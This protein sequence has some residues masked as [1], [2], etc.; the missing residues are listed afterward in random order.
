MRQSPFVQTRIPHLI[1]VGTADFRPARPVCDR[2]NLYSFR[3][4]QPWLTDSRNQPPPGLVNGR[5][6]KSLSF[7]WWDFATEEVRRQYQSCQIDSRRMSY[8]LDMKFDLLEDLVAGKLVALGFREGA[9]VAEGPVLIPAHLFP[10]G[11]EDTAVV[12]W[13]MSTLR[14]AGFSFTRIRVTKRQAGPRRRKRSSATD[15]KQPTSPL[16]PRAILATIPPATRKKMGRPS[17]EKPLREVI[18]KLVEGGKLKGNSRKAQIAII[19]DAARAAHPELF[20]RD[21]QPSRD[22]IFSA[23]RAEGLIGV[24]PRSPGSQ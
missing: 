18:Q 8:R 20:L 19:Q 9:P 14:S 16:S 23:L 5:E 21:T 24:S 11:G 4:V 6:E 17:V 15:A 3:S 7:A 22:R 12:D 10:R 1:R 2:L 13:D